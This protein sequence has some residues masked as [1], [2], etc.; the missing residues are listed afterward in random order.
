MKFIDLATIH[1]SAGRGGD[2]CISF[3]REK[4]IPKGGPDGGNGGDGGDVWIIADLNINSLTDYRIKKIFHA[5]NG[6]NGSGSNSS[7]KK[8]KD[9]FVRVPIGTRITNSE[10]HEIIADITQKN[11][12]I[13]IAKGGK[14]GSGNSK[15]KS[16]INQTPRKKTNGKFG[17]YKI[18]RLELILIADVGTL[19]LPNS[20]KSTL[21]SSVSN[22]KT[23][24]KNYP[25][26]TI[27]PVLGTVKIKKKDFIIADIPGLIKGAAS[28]IGLGINFLKHLSRCR[29]LLHVIDITKI[30]KKNI[31]KMRYI[32][33]KELKK[34]N[35]SL[36][37][38]PR[39]LIFNKIDL[40]TKKNFSKT[41]I[42]IKK[43][44]SNHQKCYFISAQKKIGVKK[45]SQ[46]I[47]QYLYSK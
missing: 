39:W 1:V 13:L 30:K 11:Q 9:F 12:K 40:L 42:Y 16:S 5:Q 22:A 43:K 14:H 3:R 31:N 4:F 7:G 34:F 18:L 36:F 8:G 32:L 47:A 21:T 33:L 15:F 10:S 26:S 35:Q 37:N 28:G 23:N 38:K 24:I 46:D 44:I 27:H 41:L 45:L 25:F 20:G 19:G 29:L 17:E 6:K 2:G